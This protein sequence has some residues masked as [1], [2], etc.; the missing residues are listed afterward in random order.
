M[1]RQRTNRTETPSGR[2][3]TSAEIIDRVLDRGVVIESR[4][5]IALGGIDTGVGVDGRYIV[6]SCDTDLEYTGTLR[7]PRRTRS[8]AQ[9]RFEEPAPAMF[10]RAPAPALSTR[11][12]RKKAASKHR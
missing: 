1:S 6:T 9:P 12:L 2:V 3:P 11:L 4:S 5:R 10:Y 8:E 7:A